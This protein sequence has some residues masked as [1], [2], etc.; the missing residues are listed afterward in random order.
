MR[1]CCWILLFFSLHFSFSQNTKEIDSLLQIVHSSKSDSLRIE[2]N[3]SLF[4]IEV[5]SNLEQSKKYFQAIFKIAQQQHSAFA[6]AKAFNLKGVYFDYKG[7]L[8]SAY[9]CYQ[10]AIQFARKAK[11]IAVEGS[12]FNNIGLLYWNKSN[13]YQAIVSYSKALK[14]F[15]KT[16]KREYQANV[17]S[18]IG[19]IYDDIEEDEKAKQ[20]LEKSLQIRKIINDEYGLSVS[21][22]NLA[23]ILEKQGHHLQA[24][25]NYE[26]GIALKRKMNDLFGLAV[27][28]H[29][30]AMALLSVK[31]Y[32]E[33][34]NC[35]KEAEVICLKNNAESNIL[36]N[37]YLGYINLYLATNNLS[38]TNEYNEKMYLVTQKNKDQ[39]RL[40]EYFQF[41]SK[42]AFKEGRYKEAYSF[43]I[44]SDS[45]HKIV[46]GLD[47]K[48]AINLYEA[49]Y[50]S[51]KKEKELFKTKNELY[52]HENESKKKS[53][54][55][56]I[57]SLATLF[58]ALV[59]MMIYRQQRLKNKQ[60]QQEFEL[61]N[62]IQAIENQ[63]QLQEQRLSISR[64]LHD[65]IGAQLTFVIS[66]IDNLKYGTKITDSTINTQLLRIS[67]F[68]KSTIVELRDTIW[69]M[70]K[71]ELTVD[72]LYSRIVNFIE[73][74]KSATSSI[75]FQFYIED[76]MKALR[77]SSIIGIT[78]YRTIQ[79]AVNN[80]I[81]YAEASAINVHVQ[82]KD[83][84]LQIEV[85]DD[86]KGFDKDSVEF[87]N[88]IQNMLQRIEEIKGQC[89]IHSKFNS[90]TRIVIQ[91]PLNIL[92]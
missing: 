23:K 92:K 82:K 29:N 44:K 70:N 51:E 14:I 43:K 7:N 66:S 39:Q 5:N 68:T 60:Q 91:I 85:S 36:E 74:A 67:E 83:D 75:Q 52:K 9:Y 11:A 49:K 88:G 18:N 57:I 56:I 69:A 32:D 90:G 84:Q 19:L 46:E 73:K 31:R 28:N 26:K 20:Y 40:S 21:Y 78:I 34:L 58:I 45:I 61:K 24:L 16:N 3:N 59:G 25:Y 27:G 80:A 42:I 41:K 81:K 6:N 1:Y 17:L 89:I 77:F 4:F 79:E 65:N 54:W 87:G 64:D 55:L 8:D 38:K 48:K 15:E 33:A 76:E 72:D 10:Q 86:G 47:L 50:Q 13:Y 30:K 62:A 53:F 12:A 71:S 2:A 37:V 35:L 22:I 63:N